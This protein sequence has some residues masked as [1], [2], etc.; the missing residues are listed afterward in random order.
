MK[1]FHYENLIPYLDMALL[2]KKTILTNPH[3]AHIGYTLESNP[4]Y[5]AKKLYESSNIYIHPDSY[6]QWKTILM[7]LNKRKPLPLKLIVFS[8]SDYFFEDNIVVELKEAFV[9][10]EFWVQNYTG[11]TKAFTIL[12]I[13]VKEDYNESIEK[14]YLFGISYA[15]NNG[16]F[17]EEFIEFLNDY[18]DMKVYCMPKV[19]TTEFYPLLSQFYFSTC[20]M[21][22]GFDTHRF[23]ECLMV[24][25]I[26][27]VKA[28]EYYDNLLFQYPNL[29]ILVVKRWEE[30][31]E[32]IKS[33]DTKLYNE[34]FD[35]ANLDILLSSYWETKAK[36]FLPQN[37]LNISHS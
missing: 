13:G 9:N 10:T 29:P 19:S 30:L 32:L 15:A 22:N 6:T 3:Y 5:V 33:L 2:D 16:G 7:L 26:P 34:L 27:I 1:Y 14:N 17:R 4:R 12:P 23:W 28:H 36:G 24:G 31:P 18:E 8:G 21:G 11:L 25:T 35:K 20:P 37:P